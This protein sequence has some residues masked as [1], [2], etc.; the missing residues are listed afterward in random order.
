MAGAVLSIWLSR[1]PF[2]RPAS[3]SS[4]TTTWFSR[5]RSRAAPWRARARVE[6]VFAR[7]RIA[8][9]PVV[10]AQIIDRLNYL[11][12]PALAG[13]EKLAS[14]RRCRAR[15]QYPA[16]GNRHGRPC[17]SCSMGACAKGLVRGAVPPWRPRQGNRACGAATASVF[18]TVAAH[19]LPSRDRRAPQV[20]LAAY[21]R[22]V[23]RSPA[24]T[25]FYDHRASP[26]CELPALVSTCAQAPL[27]GSFRTLTSRAKLLP[28]EAIAAWPSG[29]RSGAGSSSN[30]PVA[31]PRRR[32]PSRDSIVSN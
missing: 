22:G 2:R 24:R 19:R 25:P 9:G 15:L 32:L 10:G 20:P 21:R 28:D 17:A 29:Q 11:A 14:R 18:W 6:R 13:V 8:T 23:T 5:G 1:S 4:A 31:D 16:R 7:P 12:T 27:P 30:S 3:R 26:P